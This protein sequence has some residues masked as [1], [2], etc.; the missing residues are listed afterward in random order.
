MKILP[1]E[2]KIS[3]MRFTWITNN[4]ARQWDMSSEGIFISFWS[5]ELLSSASCTW[6]LAKGFNTLAVNWSWEAREKESVGRNVV[7][8]AVGSS[9]ESWLLIKFIASSILSTLLSVFLKLDIA[10]NGFYEKLQ[11]KY[12]TRLLSARKLKMISWENIMLLIFLVERLI[13]EDMK[14]LS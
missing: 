4:V 1:I 2:I 6:Q 10:C 9:T 11:S 7:A 8:E 5:D 13:K 14:I 12:I 3:R